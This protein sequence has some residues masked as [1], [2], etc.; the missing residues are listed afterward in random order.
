MKRSPIP[1]ALAVLGLL[2]WAVG[3][4]SAPIDEGNRETIVGAETPDGSPALPFP[5]TQPGPDAS[6][7]VDAGHPPHDG[8]LVPQADAGAVA[9]AA[10]A[11]G[12]DAA[13]PPMVDSGMP[14]A[15]DAGA[16]GAPDVGTPLHT[17][18]GPPGT[19]DSGGP[20]RADAGV[21]P[22]RDAGAPTP[23]GCAA[24]EPNNSFAQATPLGAGDYPQLAL[25]ANDID[26][27]KV[28]VPANHVL[29]AG[30]KFQNSKGD[31]DLYFGDGTLDSRGY[32]NTYAS[33]DSDVQDVEEILNQPFA[34]ATTTYVIVYG[35]SGAQGSYDLRLRIE[36]GVA[37]RDCFRGCADLVALGGSPTWGS[38]VAVGDGFFAATPTKYAF[39]RRDLVGLL[40]YSAREVQKRFPS[41]RTDTIGI[42]DVCQAD[43]KTPGTDVGSPRHPATT[44]VRGKDVDVAYY[45]TDGKSDPQIICGDGSDNNNNGVR[46]RYNDGYFCTTQQNIVDVPRHMWFMAKLAESPRFR[47]V[48]VDQTLVPAFKAEALKLYNAGAVGAAQ[49]RRITDGLGYGASGGWQ[50]HHH[51]IHLSLSE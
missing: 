17:D 6:S 35:E 3:C 24:F 31:L 30:I 11:P 20:V 14:S 23:T 13:S 2:P 48:G 44:H 47:V 4:E 21:L 10:V 37:D 50:F 1:W 26:M 40:R 29:T 36:P 5:A 49:H 9:D 15:I 28:Q 45:Q 7:A 16:P 12:P 51:H 38:T 27:F 46:G 41:S 34:T 22:G 8:G 25:C 19:P 43:G 42:S 18:A 33:S 32:L 39:G